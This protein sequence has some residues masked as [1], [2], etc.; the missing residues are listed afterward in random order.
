M[1]FI[2]TFPVKKSPRAGFRRIQTSTAAA[3]AYTTEASR[4]A[5][6]ITLSEVLSTICRHSL[7]H[8]HH[9]LGYQVLHL[10]GCRKRGNG[11]GTEKIDG[12]LHDHSTG[13]CNCKLQCHRN[14]HSQLVTALL[15]VKPP[16]SS[17]WGKRRH[18]YIDVDQTE[19][20]GNALRNNGCPCCS[21]N[22]HFKIDNQYQIQNYI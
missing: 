3:R 12:R 16:M 9:S 20:C 15:A 6:D 18:T 11:I 19:Y 17:V 14:S 7:S 13:S 21:G 5:L 2:S 8:S 10:A 4:D 22:A 1:L